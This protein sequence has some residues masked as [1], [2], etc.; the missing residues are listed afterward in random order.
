[1]RKYLRVLRN[2]RDGGAEPE[3][4]V[5]AR[6]KEFSPVNVKLLASF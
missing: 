1:M 4:E 3:S 6:T 2:R 5:F